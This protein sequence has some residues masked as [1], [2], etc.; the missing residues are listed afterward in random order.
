MLEHTREASILDLV[1]CDN[2]YTIDHV[3]CTENFSTSDHNSVS[4]CINT[5][6]RSARNITSF[7]PDFAKADWDNMGLML[8]L[9]NWRDVVS[10]NSGID[11]C[12]ANFYDILS[13]AI[14][15]F[16]PV[17]RVSTNNVSRK[18]V[19]PNYIR[20]LKLIK[21]KRW[22][23]LRKLSFNPILKN[24]FKTAVKALKAAMTNWHIARE[25]KIISSSNTA[26][27]FKY[28]NS[29]L[30]PGKRL[31]SIINNNVEL[32]TDPL[33]IAEAFNY[34]FASVYT[35]D[36]GN[37]PPFAPVTVSELKTCLFG[38]SAVFNILQHL[39]SSFS[40][41]LD[42][43]PNTMLK[44]MATHFSWPLAKL[45][46]RSMTFIF[47]PSV[48]KVANIVPILKK[49]NPLKVNNY[50]PIFLTSTISKVVERIINDHILSHL[51][52]NNLIGR[53]QFGFQKQCSTITP[54]N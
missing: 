2:L 28:I 8:S 1:L 12:W 38:P 15:I 45:F 52:T 22:R 41:G 44:N 17:R 24:Q 14:C 49:G 3:Y 48:W 29:K 13:Q 53:H 40:Y 5:F 34:Y 47:V 54:I 26:T 36:N 16:V 18:L 9:I 37:L 46:E 33:A 6:A 42:C 27:L 11:H 19:L 21:L 32:I 30:G 39:K 7:I 43:I 51:S 35:H 25:H 4:F 31:D 20:K 10:Y 23:A 50:R